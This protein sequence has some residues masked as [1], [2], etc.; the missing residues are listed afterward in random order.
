[1]LM[2]WEGCVHGETLRLLPGHE[3][4]CSKFRKK[5][6]KRERKKETETHTEEYQGRL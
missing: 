3:R 1:M 2:I 5:K 6:K 4:M